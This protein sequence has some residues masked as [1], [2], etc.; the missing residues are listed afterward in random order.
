M[1]ILFLGTGAADWNHWEHGAMADYRRNASV[2]IDDVLLID[3]GPDVSEALERFGRS[4]NRITHILNTHRHQDHYCPETVRKLGGAEL[5]QIAVGTHAM[6]GGYRVSA[7]SA[8]HGTCE[9]TT[10]FLISDGRSSLF[11]GLDGAW[12]M[13]D[14]VQALRKGVDY[15]VID[16]T[17]GDAEGDY[18]IFEHNNLRMVQEMKS[19]LAPYVGRWCLSH[20]SR[21]LHG[22]HQALCDRM[23]PY[24]FEVA[25]DGYEAEF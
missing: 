5:V 14:E 18:R 12:L 21:T 23:K 17:I 25:Y 11:Y 16:A 10:H 24:G 19:T 2:L 15:A 1:K 3:P 6:V 8:N 20:M 9:G 4:S 7:L 22:S 13:Y